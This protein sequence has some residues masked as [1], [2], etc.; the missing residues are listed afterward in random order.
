MRVKFQSKKSRDLF[1]KEIE[2]K[3]NL[4]REFYEQFKISRKTLDTY[5]SGKMTLPLDFYDSVCRHFNFKKENVEYLEDNWGRIKGGKAAYIKNKHFFDLGR[6]ILLKK[7]SK[8]EPLFNINLPL[9]AE[10][11]HFIGLFIG[12]GFM[13][14]Y[15]YSYQIQFTGHIS[16]FG[17]YNK[18]ISKVIKDNFNLT[19]KIKEDKYVANT[20]RVNL[21]SKDLFLFL[22]QRFKIS[23]GRK[24]Y[25]VM[26]PEEIIKSPFVLDCIAG[27]FDAEGCSYF[28][29]RKEYKEKYPCI[30]LH[31][32]NPG[33]VKQMSDILNENNIIHSTSKG[34][35]NIFIYGKNNVSVFCNKVQLRNS[36]IKEKL[37]IYLAK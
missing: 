29:T 25:T 5:K 13:N 2:S 4:W 6:S 36:K 9:S 15:G 12:D 10:I 16:E 17:F 18:I 22:S 27:I 33:L 1:F 11:S 8:R 7:I 30:N 34:Y 24:S 20:I 14:R 28:D 35:A 32:N 26:I 21:N 3:I 19:A 37:E 23:P 31:M